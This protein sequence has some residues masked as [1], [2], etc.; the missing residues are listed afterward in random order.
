MTGSGSICWCKGMLPEDL[1][2]RR[3]FTF[4]SDSNIK[5]GDKVILCNLHG[6]AL[7]LFVDVLEELHMFPSAAW[8]YDE[9]VVNITESDEGLEMG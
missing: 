1:V 4:L 2:G 9:G 8:P 7:V 5:H 3:A 6:D